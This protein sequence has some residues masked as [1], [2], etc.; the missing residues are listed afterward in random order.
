MLEEDNEGFGINSYN[1]KCDDP[2]CTNA[3]NSSIYEEVKVIKN[4]YLFIIKIRNSA[5][6]K[7]W[8]Q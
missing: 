6:S 5:I 7:R 1:V 4:V 3:L 8:Y 2:S